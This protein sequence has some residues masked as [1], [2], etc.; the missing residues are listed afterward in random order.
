[1][2]KKHKIIYA[3]HAK[4]RTHIFAKHAFPKKSVFPVP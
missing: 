1:M 3:K 4:V 2:K